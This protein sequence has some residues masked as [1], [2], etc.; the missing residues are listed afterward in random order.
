VGGDGR[1]TVRPD[2][3]E[4]GDDWGSEDICSSEKQGGRLA[5]PQVGLD[6]WGEG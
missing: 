1:A 4:T 6:L 2:E 5:R 3:E